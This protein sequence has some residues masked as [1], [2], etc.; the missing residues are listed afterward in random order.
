MLNY[1]KGKITEITA[2]QVVIFEC[3]GIG[4]EIISDSE[5][6]NQETDK[7]IKIY[8]I[9]IPG[10]DEFRLYG[11]L[12]RTKRSLFK[13][14]RT[15]SGLGSKSAM[16][17]VSSVSAEDISQAILTGNIVYL[18]GLPGVGNKTAERIV[19]ELRNK[20][21]ELAVHTSSTT[22]ESNSVDIDLFSNALEGLTVLGYPET[23]SKNI[24]RDI[25]AE[26]EQEW[27]V[28]TLIKS[29]LKRFLELQH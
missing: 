6:I 3:G 22:E 4:Y 27:K 7:E 15:V 5:L 10:E 21:S 28:E 16:K 19:L 14:L 23:L 12:T 13:L 18:K 2:D 26:K 9:M 29:A 24:L 1:I 25:L 8:V 17:I 20:I 11:F